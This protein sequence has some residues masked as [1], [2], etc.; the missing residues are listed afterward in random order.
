MMNNK[1]VYHILI[2]VCMTSGLLFLNEL[3]RKRKVVKKLYKKLDNTQSSIQA[4]EFD[5]E[6]LRED[7]LKLNHSLEMFKVNGIDK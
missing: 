1:L 3:R 2:D 6:M 4:I 7:Y 5:M